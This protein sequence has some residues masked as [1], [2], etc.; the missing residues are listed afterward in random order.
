[1]SVIAAPTPVLES[2]P[3]HVDAEFTP[4]QAERYRY[5]R[6]RILL[7]SIVGYAMYYFVRKNLSFAMP[8]MEEQLHVTKTTLGIYLSAHGIVYGVS[9]FLNGIVADR[10]NARWFMPLGL[11]LSAIVN[12]FF[13]FSTAVVTLGILWVINGWV[14]GMG[15]PPC[16]RL[17]VHWFSP[18]ELATKMGIWNTSHCIGAA[19][20]YLL[21]AGVLAIRYDWRLCFFAPA[22]LAILTS[23]LLMIFLRDTPESVGLPPVGGTYSAEAEKHRPMWNVLM[24]RVFNNRYI[25]IFCVAKFFVYVIRYSI[26]DW[27]PTMLKQ[28]KGTTL[29]NAAVMLFFF[30]VAGVCGAIAGGWITDKFFRGRCAR[31]SFF[32]MLGSGAALFVFWKMPGGHLMLGTGLLMLAGFFV[33]VPQ[34]LTGI[35]CANLATKEAAA[36]AA[37]LAG[38]FAYGSTVVTGT[39]IGYIAQHYGW[40][41]AFGII[42]IAAVAGAA[43]FAVNWNAPRDGYQLPAAQAL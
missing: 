11:I 38:L 27:G 29:T 37:G 32:C 13:G 40:D 16:A 17:M 4:E 26:F 14:Q 42:L 23:G 30:E 39:G 22:A 18:K 31:T 7:W 19:L 21:C 41:W 10:V 35:A 25:W 8:V 9:K 1:M 6:P 2:A 20:V 43:L 24:E 34:A 36:S 12:I 5:Y 28:F 15:F 3:A 33:Y